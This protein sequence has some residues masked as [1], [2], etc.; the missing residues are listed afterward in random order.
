MT[1]E[2]MRKTFASEWV[3]I[4]DPQ[5]GP[6]REVVAGRVAFHSKDRHEVYRKAIELR[7][8]KFAM[9]FTGKLMENTALVFSGPGASCRRLE[10][11][12]GRAGSDQGPRLSVLLLQP[13]E[14]RARAHSRG[15]RGPL[16]QVLVGS[17]RTCYGSWVSRT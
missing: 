5:L 12:L 13:R 16:R 6:S 17:G 3:L 9:Y 4:Q 10:I 8:K 2:E 14:P 1:V 11:G 15:A 7:P